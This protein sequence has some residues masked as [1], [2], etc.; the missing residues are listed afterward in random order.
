MPQLFRG[1]A[2]VDLPR[3]EW[4]TRYVDGLVKRFLA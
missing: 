2:G 1:A 4:R 3:P